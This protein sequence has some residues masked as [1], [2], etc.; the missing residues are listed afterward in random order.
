MYKLEIKKILWKVSVVANLFLPNFLRRKHQVVLAKYLEVLTSLKKKKI[1]IVGLGAGVEVSRFLKHGAKEIVG[2][3]PLPIVE[4]NQ[5]G[6]KFKLIKS[7]GEALPFKDNI[8]DIVYSVA[9]LEHVRNPLKVVQEMMRVLRPGG[10]FYCQAGPLWYSYSGY[11]PKEKYSDID[12]NWFHLLLSKKDV[13]GKIEHSKKKEYQKHL[14]RIYDSDVYNRLSAFVYYKTCSWLLER[15]TPMEVRFSI[16]TE[17]LRNFQKEN[18]SGY[19]K[20]FSKH[21][22]RDLITNDFIWV[23]IK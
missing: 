1:L 16:D 18:P 5:F 15:F 17:R 20:L 3:D 9:T 19:R 6:K 13:L 11:H 10:L 21:K 12:G 4:E 2:V 22:K 7:F 14:E 23:F 8:F